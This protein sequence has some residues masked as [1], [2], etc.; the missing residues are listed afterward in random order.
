MTIPSSLAQILGRTMV[1]VAHPD[2]ESIACGGLLQKMRSPFVVFATDG[3]PE[4]DFFWGRYG[5]RAA[6]SKLRQEEALSALD[7]VGVSE[8]EFLAND[9]AESVRLEDQKL[10]RMIRTALQLLRKMIEE[11][12]PDALLTLAYE[13]GHPD[14][15]TCSFLAAQLGRESRL[16]IWEMPLYHR[17]SDGSGVYQRFVREAKDEVIEVAITGEML[18]RKERMLQSYKSQF[19]ALPHFEPERERFRPQAQYDY[20]QPPHPGKTNY[21]VWQWAMTAKEV[22]DAFSAALDRKEQRGQSGR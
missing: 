22:C 12:R 16:P 4:D 2:D 17:N 7:Q 5:S 15:D 20:T 8:V 11:K 1:L 14:H 19:D 9:A 3:A 21:E 13:G 6:Y 18:E 10:F